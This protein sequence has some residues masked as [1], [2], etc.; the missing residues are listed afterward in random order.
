M[1]SLKFSFPHP[2]FRAIIGSEIQ[3]E[4]RNSAKEEEKKIPIH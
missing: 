1:L 4:Y 3:L 2:Q